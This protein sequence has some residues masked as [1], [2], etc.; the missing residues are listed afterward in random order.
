MRDLRR[1]LGE[2]KGWEEMT[3]QQGKYYGV[4]CN[5]GSHPSSPVPNEPNRVTKVKVF[6]LGLTADLP[7]RE[8]CTAICPFCGKE[9][10]CSA[11]NIR[12]F[13]EYDR[14]LRPFVDPSNGPEDA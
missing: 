9:I 10:D 3:K 5:D 8:P 4:S 12:T 13:D 1:R 7:S 2:G 11:G 6:A 14:K